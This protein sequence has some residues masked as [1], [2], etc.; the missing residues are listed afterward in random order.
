MRTGL[1]R[2]DLLRWLREDQPDRLESLW[3]WADEVRRGA[4][5]DAVHLRGLV[6]ISNHCARSCLYCGLRAANVEVK[7][8]R[9]SR[10]EILDAARHARS[11][12]YGSLVL[13]GGEDP[14]LTGPWIADVVRRVKAET[15][16]AVTLSLGERTV[17]DLRL[18][19]DSGADRYLLRF[20][21]SNR[22]LFDAIHPGLRGTRSDR[23]ELLG[24]LRKLG[25]E[26]GG[27]F[28][29]GLPG[30][31]WEDVASDLLL[32]AELDLDMI[33]I[34][35]FL[36]HPNT[37]LGSQ[38]RPPGIPDPGED[39]VPNTALATCKALAL[40]RILCPEA[41]IP[42]T[43]ALATINPVNGRELGLARGGNVLMPNMTPLGWRK[44]YEI[45]PAKACMNETSEQCRPC[46]LGRIQRIGRCVG[47]GPGGRTHR[48]TS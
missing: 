3:A 29:I 48:Q 4:V 17:A 19:R 27:G 37:P 21:T 30:Q 24:I 20:E 36:P 13:Q 5:G 8:Y 12:G 38:G 7:R 34:G 32:C 9:M 44:H 39:Q 22:L 45:Y 16:L 33:G 26:T 25:Y 42:S 46:V 2:G 47:T 31:S 35:P 41:N 14:F 40:A 15:G 18:W 11:F 28:M 1:T 6:E 43:T 23:V 10:E